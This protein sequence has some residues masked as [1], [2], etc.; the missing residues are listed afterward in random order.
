MK[1]TIILLLVLLILITVLGVFAIDNLK[2]IEQQMEDCE[3]ISGGQY[4]YLDNDG[5]CCITSASGWY[6]LEED[7]I[8]RFIFGKNKR[9]REFDCKDMVRF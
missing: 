6:E 1:K 5:R 3:S 4:W 2:E 9:W 8:T 7:T